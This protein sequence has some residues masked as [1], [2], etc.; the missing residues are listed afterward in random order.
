MVKILRHVSPVALSLRPPNEMNTGLLRF[1]WWRGEAQRAGVESYLVDARLPAGEGE[2][3]AQGQLGSLE[4]HVVQEVSDALHDVVKQLQGESARHTGLAV[5]GGGWLAP[6]SR[7]PSLAFTSSPVPCMISRGMAKIL[8]YIRTDLRPLLI[9]TRR[10]RKLVPPRSRARNF[11][12]SVVEKVGLHSTRT[13]TAGTRG[14][15]LGGRG[16]AEME[17]TGAC[18]R[19]APRPEEGGGHGARRGSPGQAP[20]DCLRPA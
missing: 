12:F 14:E 3:E 11:P 16:G 2:R 18:T 6:R 15:A 20:G 9:F 17:Q 5:A 13:H 8:L 7:N 19:G 10:T 4:A 1:R